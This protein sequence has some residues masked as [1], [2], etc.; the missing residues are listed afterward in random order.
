LPARHAIGDDAVIYLIQG[1]K[2]LLYAHDTGYFYDEVFDYLEKNH[3]RLDLISLDCTNVDLPI[4]NSQT[5]MGVPN[6]LDAVQRLTDIGAVDQRTIKF[7]NHFSHN[8][9]P[10]HHVLEERVSPLGYHV[11]YDGLAVIF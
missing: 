11:A 5:H 7:I 3:I 4:S 9:N 6:I 8:A 2:T 10:L 1:E